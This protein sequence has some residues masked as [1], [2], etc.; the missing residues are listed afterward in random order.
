M[1]YSFFLSFILSAGDTWE[2]RCL[3]DQRGVSDSAQVS[4][5]YYDNPGGCSGLLGCLHDMHIVWGRLP[6]VVP[7]SCTCLADGLIVLLLAVCSTLSC[8]AVPCDAA[9]VQCL[10]HDP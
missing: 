4:S 6:G 1:A 3:R 9:S 10:P 5:V 8:H 7:G 2:M